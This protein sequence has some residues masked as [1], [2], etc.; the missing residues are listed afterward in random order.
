VL[1]LGDSDAPG[2]HATVNG[3]AQRVARVDQIMRG[4]VVPAG[5]SVV[6]FR[7][8]SRPRD[9]GAVISLVTLAALVL[10]AAGA[11]VRATR[12]RRSGRVPPLV[13]GADC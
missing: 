2:W 1:V 5:R 7:Y 4:I 12:L 11:V 9:V 10:L 13:T 3:K 8:R 6:V